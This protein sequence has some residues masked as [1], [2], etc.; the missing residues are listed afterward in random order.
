MTKT[1]LKTPEILDDVS[2]KEILKS[3]L[4][5]LR[6]KAE[7]YKWDNAHRK[8]VLQ[9]Q[10]CAFEPSF[11]LGTSIVV[12]LDTFEFVSAETGVGAL[13]SFVEKFGN[14]ASGWAFDV[15][16]PTVLGGNAWPR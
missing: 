8:K 3:R 16:R 1:F 5:T 4:Q 6:K 14:E 13:K 7:K 10:E 11:P 9:N 15:D 2:D 12:N